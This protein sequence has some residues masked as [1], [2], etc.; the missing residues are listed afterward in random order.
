MASTRHTGL[1][2]LVLMVA[3][4]TGCTSTAPQSAPSDT[5]APAENDSP[6]S[7]LVMTPSGG[8]DTVNPLDPVTVESVGGRLDSVVLTEVGGA[9]VD[10]IFT[11]DRQVWKPGA[12]LDYGKTYTMTASAT[13]NDGSR[14]DQSSTFSTV[15]PRNL[16]KPSF[17]TAGGNLLTDG[18]TFGVGIVIVTHFDEPILDRAAAEK[19]LTVQT[20]VPLEGSWYWVDDQNVHWRPRAYYPPGTEVTVRA[21]VFGV[22]L[23]GGLFGQEDATTAFTI[24]DSHIA[25]ADD[26]TKQVTVTSNGKTVRTMPTSMGMG[27][28]ELVN[29]QT[30]SFWT[31]PGIY[32]VLDQANPVIMDSS[33]YGLPVNSRLGYKEK[34]NYATRISTDGI[35]LHE[36]ED[37]VWAQGNT[38]VSHGCLNLSRANAQ[39]FYDFSLP[40]DVVEI[41]NTGGA[42]LE[43]WQNGDWSVPWDRWSEGS[44]L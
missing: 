12:S 6:V 42:P 13:Q 29:G 5:G 3:T 39:W 8:T 22:P 9:V 38:N 24:G 7:A 34:I 37:T 16:T 41:R 15:K 44:A 17:V 10:G 30:I 31:Q 20:S 25:V 28:T 36:L 32:T 27:G 40:G 14:L 19:S 18:G 35:Y 21:A 4:L 33:T 1:L 43:L 26:T 11:P 23:G 2:V